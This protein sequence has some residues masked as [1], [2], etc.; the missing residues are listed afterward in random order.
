MRQLAWNDDVAATVASLRALAPAAGE[1]QERRR[2]D[3]DRRPR[4]RDVEAVRA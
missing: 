3:H 1:V 2:D 4:D